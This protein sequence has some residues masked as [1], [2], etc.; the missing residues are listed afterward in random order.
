VERLCAR[1]CD[2]L[3]TVSPIT[4]E[5]CERLLGRAPDL[6]TPNGLNIDRFDL[7]HD[8][9]NVHA[10]YKEEI[11]HFVMGH[12]FPSYS[13]DLDRTL[14]FFNA[15]RFEPR[16]KGFDLC[17]EVMARLNAELRSAQLGITV[18]FFMV[19]ARPIIS[20]DP[21]VLNARGVL[22]ELLEVSRRIGADVGERLFRL[23]AAGEVVGLDDLVEE[24]WRLRHRR[25]QYAFRSE[26]LPP[27]STHVI[28]DPVGDPLL[29][30]LAHLN[31]RNQRDDP[32][33]VVYHPEF[34]SS[35]SPLWGIDY[36]HFVRGC[37]L[38]IFPSSYEPWG[39]TPLE[40]VA[41]GVPAITSDLAGFGRYVSE[42]FPDH[43][44]WGLVVLR[45]RGRRFHEAAADLTRRVLQFCRL[46]RRGRIAQRNQV[47]AHSRAFDWSRLA[48]AYHEAHDRA[49]GTPSTSA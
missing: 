20:L 21:H 6:I 5:E 7:G 13:F 33:K 49:L 14:Y 27:V 12:F 11:H 18:V 45:R 17:L 31:L 24:Y 25:V 1:S 36:E 10:Q 44:D 4:G 8:F 41:M 23:S 29:A 37:H 46:D 28:D 35:V 15:G 38:G 47:E 30:H 26:R 34:I 16:N 40:C 48:S 2:V 22:S 9:Q 42:V 43:D 39:Y 19:T 3:T 32:V